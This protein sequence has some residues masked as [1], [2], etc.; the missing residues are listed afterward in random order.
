MAAPSPDG[1]GRRP[2]S[3]DGAARLSLDPDGWRAVLQNEPFHLSPAEVGQLTDRQAWEWFIKPGKER[4]E[5]LKAI[6]EGRAD[7][8]EAD[9]P[10]W[11]PKSAA[12]TLEYLKRLGV[13]GVPDAPPGSKP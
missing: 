11:E 5:R 9:A 10:A 1:R 8:A 12:E 2:K 3:P 13:V 4:A 7:P 6:R